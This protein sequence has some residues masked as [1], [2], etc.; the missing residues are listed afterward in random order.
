MKCLSHLRSWSYCLSKDISPSNCLLSLSSVILC[1][2][3]FTFY[4]IVLVFLILF[5]RIL[6]TLCHTALKTKRYI[7]LHVI[8]CMVS[9]HFYMIRIFQNLLDYVIYNW[10]I[11]FILLHAFLKILCRTDF[12]KC[13][14]IQG[15]FLLYLYSTW[16]SWLLSHNIR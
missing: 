1:L 5:F 10:F 15:F 2:I 12:L 16:N 8:L 14:S 11:L 3:F 4:L 13:G 6:S 9:I 7:L